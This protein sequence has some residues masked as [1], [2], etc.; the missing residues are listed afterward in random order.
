MCR[1][2]SSWQRVLRLVY[3]SL[4]FMSFL[5]QGKKLIRMS[6]GLVISPNPVCGSGRWKNA[7]GDFN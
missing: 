5:I 1:L 6:H 2:F 7:L 4:F 3:E